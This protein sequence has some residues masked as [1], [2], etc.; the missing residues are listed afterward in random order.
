M[1]IM[2]MIRG[3]GKKRSKSMGNRRTEIINN[4]KCPCEKC[5]Q[6]PYIDIDFL[7]ISKILILEENTGKQVHI[8]S[9]N[10]CVEYNKSIGGY[11]GSPH[12]PRPKGEASDMQIKGMNNIR[13]AYEAERAG[14]KRIGIYP[15]HV[16][17]DMI[18]P[19]PSKYWYLKSYQSVA[20]YSKGIKTLK[21]FL[22]KLKKEGGLN[23]NDLDMVNNIGG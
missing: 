15:N 21:E 23:Q 18:D 11:S 4:M 22:N 9:G 7:L 1:K 10:R 3:L 16:H 8:T 13:L 20:V 17:G 14:F 2:G 12:I 6:S 19:R 5:S